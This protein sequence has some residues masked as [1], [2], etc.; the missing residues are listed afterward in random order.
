MQMRG[1]KFIIPLLIFIFT[2]V[3]YS[4]NLYSDF[5]SGDY[6]RLLPAG[7][8]VPNTFLPY[9][10]LKDKTFVFDEQVQ[11]LRRFE[12]WVT[13]PVFLIKRNGHYYSAYPPLTGILTVPFY[14][15]Q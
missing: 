6:R 1:K 8:A 15:F 9:I 4:L 2:L 14:F 7:D 10:L 11:H 12:N 13:D 5:H 3:I